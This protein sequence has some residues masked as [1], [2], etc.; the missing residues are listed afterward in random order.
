MHPPLE[1]PMAMSVDV[2]E[3]FQVQAFA[4]RI[5]RGEWS[6]WP[7][8]IEENLD[9]LL[10][11]LAETNSKGTFFVLGCVAQS[12]PHVVRQI[13]AQGHEKRGGGGKVDERP[14]GLQDRT[15]RP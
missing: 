9:R 7:S 11:L 8:R 4:R 15:I 6:R 13:A 5:P 1:P 14:L 12:H 10:A 3:Y 2:E